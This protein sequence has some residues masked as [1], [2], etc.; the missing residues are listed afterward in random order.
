MNGRDKQIEKDFE[1]YKCLQSS[2]IDMGWQEE[3]WGEQM[4]T[5]FEW[6]FEQV[7]FMDEL[8]SSAQLT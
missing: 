3:D 1:K 7:D 4:K 2:E 6:L 8:L 5:T